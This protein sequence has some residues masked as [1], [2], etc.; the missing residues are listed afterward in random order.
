MWDTPAQCGKRAIM[1]TK[2]VLI[3]QYDS[4]FVRRVAV[5][6][7][8]YG[9]AFE[10]RVL[11]TFADFDAMLE[12]GPLGKVPVLVLADG[13]H[14]WDSR[15]IL[16]FLHGQASQ[17]RLLLPREEPGRRQ[18]LRVEAVAIGLAEKAYERGLEFARRAAGTQDPVW[19]ARLE[20]QIASALAWLEA[21]QPGPFLCVPA[22]SV[23]DVT[24]AVAFT[25]ISEKWP[26]LVGS[27]AYPALKMHRAAC[28]AMPAFQAAPYS[29]TE[30]ARSGWRPEAV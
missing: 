25:Y 24:T 19:I 7:H 28:E 3:G 13:E 10:R 11:S 8:H 18:V 14:L 4:P 15:A 22:F 6:L 17:E 30:A 9:V 29:A 27:G 20:R 1:T 23:A 16:D 26:Q 2:P 5:V 12:L 21:R